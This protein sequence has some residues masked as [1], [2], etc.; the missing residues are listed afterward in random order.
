V[1]KFLVIIFILTISG[2]SSSLAYKNLDWLAYW[3]IDE[4]IQLTE[5]QKAIVDQNLTIWLAWHRQQELPRYLAN[6]NELT[7]DIVS[8]QFSI[9]K[10]TYHQEILLQHWQRM[11]AKLVPDLVLMAPLLSAQQ[12]SELFATLDK[13]NAEERE[14]IQEKFALSLKQQQ[15]NAEKRYNKNLTRWLGKL[16]SEQETVTAEKESYLQPND[17]LWLEYRERYQ[18][19]LKT[20]FEQ[21]D[22]SKP[23]NEQLFQLLMAPEVFRSNKLNQINADNSARF[24][25]LLLTVHKMTTAKQRKKLVREINEFAKDTSALM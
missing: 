20:L 19:E 6:L 10:L 12:V 15:N 8:Q 2:C 17:I 16:T 9:E 25:F 5:E 24:K 1:K 4:Y 21:A 13:K 23:F 7:S 22:R 3:Y 14:E 18:T 11:K